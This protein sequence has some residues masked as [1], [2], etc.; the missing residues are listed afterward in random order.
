MGKPV[1]FVGYRILGK[2]KFVLRRGS[3]R[4]IYTFIS[5]FTQSLTHVAT[6]QK[7]LPQGRRERRECYQVSSKIS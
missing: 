3:G 1:V 6:K 7:S 4:Q 2:Y 5:I